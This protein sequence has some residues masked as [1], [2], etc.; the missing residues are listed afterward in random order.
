MQ[1]GHPPSAERKIGD[2][3]LPGRDGSVQ[4]GQVR[5]NQVRDSQVRDSTG[6][7]ANEP[8]AVAT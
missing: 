6:R 1:F 4:D 8:E 7:D 3:R 5:D 2:K